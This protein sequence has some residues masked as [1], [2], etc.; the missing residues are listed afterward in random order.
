MV[1]GK[2]EEAWHRRWCRGSGARLPPWRPGSGAAQ[3]G[4]W[5]QV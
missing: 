2:G 3:R 4:I 1:T 5:R